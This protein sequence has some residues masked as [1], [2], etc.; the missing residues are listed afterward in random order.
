[1]DEGEPAISGMARR[2]AAGLG[3]NLGALTLGNMAETG[4]SLP[5]AVVDTLGSIQSDPGAWL[6]LTFPM[7]AGRLSR[8]LP[9][10]RGASQRYIPSN[11]PLNAARGAAGINYAQT[12]AEDD[13]Q[14][15]LL[16]QSDPYDLDAYLRG[17]LDRG[18]T[19][20]EEEEE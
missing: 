8:N 3:T 5:E 4:D 17:I 14:G 12:Q 10:V 16:G 1:M 18:S 13:L 19:E 11:V 20:D 7:G 9:G 2:G 15:S 6:A